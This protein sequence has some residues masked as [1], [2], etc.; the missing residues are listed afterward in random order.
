[1]GRA[2]KCGSNGVESGGHTSSNP[3][4]NTAESRGKYAACA[5]SAPQPRNA[6][7]IS[8][9]TPRPSTRGRSAP[10]ATASPRIRSGRRPRSGSGRTRDCGIQHKHCAILAL[11]PPPWPGWRNWQTQRT[12]N[13]PTLAVMGVRPPLPAPKTLVSY[14]HKI[15]NLHLVSTPA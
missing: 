8:Q 5:R 13:P 12:Q 2:R 7:T 3:M 1:M 11:T 9:I 15:N 14:T 4:A 6:S 10:G